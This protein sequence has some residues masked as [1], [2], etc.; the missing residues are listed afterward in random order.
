MLVVFPFE[1]KIYLENNVDA[2]FVGHP[3]IAGFNNY[4]FL[5]KEE[6][7]DKFCLEKNKDILLLLSG[8]REHEVKSIFPEC[9]KAAENIAAKFNL[10]IVTACADNI[11]EELYYSLNGNIDFKVIKGFTYDLMKH[12]KMGIIKSGTSTLEA[13]LLELPMIIVYKTSAITYLIGKKLIRIKD[14][15]MANILSDYKVVPELI[16]SQVKADYIFNEACKILSNEEK[17]IN[18]KKELNKIKESL[19]QEDASKK[20]AEI[21]Y[22]SIYEN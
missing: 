18:T 16:Q 9:I 6:L 17:Y 8:S 15:G 10:Q 19:G 4:R 7:Y 12:S 20:A 1:E 22:S 11:N 5:T 14:I 3:L 21:I 13:A 2:V